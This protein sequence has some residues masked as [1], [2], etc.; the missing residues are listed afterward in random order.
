V[1]EATTTRRYSQHY[2]TFVWIFLLQ[3]QS[4]FADQ[5]E[6]NCHFSGL[7]LELHGSPLSDS[8]FS[9]IATYKKGNQLTYVSAA[10]GGRWVVTAAFNFISERTVQ[11][12]KLQLVS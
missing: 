12:K 3:I 8:K 2:E 5:V 11:E 10:P 4:A 7:R 6:S 9:S 1:S